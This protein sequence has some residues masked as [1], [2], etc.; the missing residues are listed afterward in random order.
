[1]PTPLIHWGL[2][3]VTRSSDINT[4]LVK[5]IP[6]YADMPSNLEYSIIFHYKDPCAQDLR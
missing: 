2:S 5:T 6:M 1:M 3:L 4:S